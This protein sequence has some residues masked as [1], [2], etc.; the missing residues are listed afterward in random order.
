MGA[1]KSIHAGKGLLLSF[2]FL[3]SPPH[4]IASMLSA[5]GSDN[6]AQFSYSL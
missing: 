2:F 6:A 4:S 1:R 3:F 5:G